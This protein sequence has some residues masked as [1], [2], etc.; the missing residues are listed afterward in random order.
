MRGLQTRGPETDHRAKTVP[1]CRIYL[2]LETGPATFSIVF[3]LPLSSLSREV[4]VT[5][6]IT[7]KAQAYSLAS[8]ALGDRFVSF[9]QPQ[10]M[11]GHGP[12]ASPM[13][14]L[15]AA[16]SLASQRSSQELPSHQVVAALP[17]ADVTDS[18]TEFRPRTPNPRTGLLP[19]LSIMIRP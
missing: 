12:S 7:P 17:G 18:L 16:P 19:P 9:G 10:S 15:L 1:I 3:G 11:S 2:V 8:T 13:L 5:T 4:N 14:Q 6:V